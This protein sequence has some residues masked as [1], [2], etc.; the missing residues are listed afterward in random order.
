MSIP[1]FYVVAGELEL[2]ELKNPIALN[3]QF[4]CVGGL[5]IFV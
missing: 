3:G 1:N 5:V 4:T 2:N